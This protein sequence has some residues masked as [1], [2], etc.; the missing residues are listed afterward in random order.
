MLTPPLWAY[1][2][3]GCMAAHLLGVLAIQQM[4]QAFWTALPKLP[5]RCPWREIVYPGT[6]RIDG[7]RHDVREGAIARWMT[8]LGTNRTCRSNG[9]TSASGSKPENICSPRV[10]RLLTQAV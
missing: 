10:F 1:L 3:C 6:T 9:A 8:A 2:M 7:T 4:G 5:W